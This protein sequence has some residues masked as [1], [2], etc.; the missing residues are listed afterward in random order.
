MKFKFWVLTILFLFGFVQPNL[1]AQNV[2]FPSIEPSFDIKSEKSGVD[3]IYITISEDP[4][5]DV[6]DAYQIWYHEFDESGNY[7]S[8]KKS[9][10]SNQ[11]A[12]N[13]QINDSHGYELCM[14][15]LD[16]QSNPVGCSFVD[17]INPGQFIETVSVQ[18]VSGTDIAQTSGTS[19]LAATL[20]I[21]AQSFPDVSLLSKITL[22]GSTYDIAELDDSNIKVYEDGRLQSIVRIIPPEG[23][24][25]KSVDIVFV[26]DDSGSLGN[27]AAQVKANIATFLSQLDSQNFDYRVALVP[28]GGAGSSSSYSSPGGTIL[29]SGQM[30]SDGNSLISDINGM[31]FNGGTERAF[32]AMQLATN[33]INWRS[34]SQKVIILVTDENND[35]GCLGESALISLLTD[36]NVTVYALTAGHSEFTRIAEATGGKR[37]SVTASFTSILTEIGEAIAS[38][39]I[40]EY[41][42]DN[43]TLDGGGREVELVINAENGE[44]ETVETSV[45]GE[46][47]PSLPISIVPTAATTALHD[48][49]QRQYQSLT[50]IVKATGGSTGI[51]SCKLY[52]KNQ[53]SSYSSVTMSDSGNDLYSATIPASSV[54]EPYV[55][56]YITATDGQITATLPSSDASSSPFVISVF[57]NVNPVINHSPVLTASEN[58]AIEI[59]ANVQDATNYI[60]E[61]TL[62]YREA[63]TSV[64]SSI[65]ANPN[66]E[67]HLF[68]TNIPAGTVTSTGVEYYLIA[69]DD[70]GGESTYGTA[71]DPVVVEVTG[72]LPDNGY[73]DIGNIRVWADSFLENTSDSNI[74]TAS[75]HVMV[76]TTQG[77][78]KLLRFSTSLVLDFSINSVEGVSSSTI[79]ALNIKRNP[80]KTPENF[81]LYDGD[82][83]ID[84]TVNPPKMTIENGTSELRLIGSLA[85][86]YNEVQDEVTIGDN[87]LTINDVTA[88]IT[89]GI[90]IIFTVGD[91][92][93]SQDGN[94]QGEFTIS[95]AD[96]NTAAKIY[97]SEWELPD[98]SLTLDTV[99]PAITGSAKI[100][101]PGKIKS[102]DA[103]VSFDLGFILSPF[104]LETF[105]GGISL[106]SNVQ[107]LLT[108]PTTPPSALGVSLKDGSIL[109]D[110]ISQAPSGLQLTGSCTVALRDAA[111][112]M[113]S[114]AEL[115]LDPV[116]GKLALTIDFNGKVR[117]VGD[118]DFIEHF[119]LADGE[120]CFG[121][122]SYVKGGINIVDVLL[123]DV[124]FAVGVASGYVDMTGQ[125]NLTFQI[126]SKAPWIGGY[127]LYNQSTYGQFRFNSSSISRAEFRTSYQLFFLDLTVRLDVSDPSDPDLFI[128]GLDKT[129]Q[130]FG[131]QPMLLTALSENTEYTVQISNQYSQAVVR[132]TADS[133]TPLFN[134]TTP[135]GVTHTPS[136][137][138]PS[139]SPD[140][141][142]ASSVS[143][144]FFMK[145][146][147]ANESF[148]GIENPE[149]GTYT[150]TLTNASE[151]SN[152][153]VGVYYPNTA[154][155]I[156]IQEPATDQVFVSDP[157][158]ISWTGQ[159]P[160]DNAVVSLYYDT[161]NSGADGQLI[162]ADINLNSETSYDWAIDDT[163]P[164]GKYYIYAVADDGCNAFKIAYSTG[165]VE[166]NN[167][168]APAAPENLQ[169]V[170]GDG[171]LTVSWDAVEDATLVGYRIY[172]STS[173]GDGE[174]ED[175]IAVGTAT[176]YD[177]EG[178]VNGQD[179]EVA[180]TAENEQFESPKTDSVTAAP[181]GSSQGGT[182]DLIVDV[183]NCSVSSSSGVHTGTVTVNISVL[184]QGEYASYSGKVTCYRGQ[185]SK[186]NVVGTKLLAGLDPEENIEFSFT[187]DGSEYSKSEADTFFVVIDDVSLTELKTDNNIGVFANGLDMLGDINGDDV[188]DSSDYA[189]FQAA[190]N[191]CFGDSRFVDL[192]DIDRDGCITINDYRLL[193]ALVS[194]Q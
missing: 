138:T 141:F 182:P 30:H 79:T 77:D 45:T 124:S 55:Y 17:E 162:A 175:D 107:N 140:D 87:S 126:P 92:V 26:H 36:N 149:G 21:D 165:T 27:E 130:V 62:Y 171:K 193:R 189:A 72:E 71:D 33:S 32:C 22:D 43:P 57:P 78:S 48:S 19:S 160:D 80:S 121:N 76:G 129:I 13:F 61:V 153:N 188:I 20:E 10:I 2:D 133:G 125:S 46:Y 174:Y 28:Y 132:V 122:P 145:N 5:S 120:I 155:T 50:I 115:G 110:K 179:Y 111:M 38:N 96:F 40:I 117:L 113:S 159:D 69:K 123:G 136:S 98:M 75:G 114:L 66:T 39:Y 85:L 6:G 169:V 191:S 146:D 14:V 35:S 41:E 183:E 95:S 156:A 15:V 177:I 186:D 102:D 147:G 93:L 81:I 84:C 52:Y 128:T 106:S 172:L 185:I 83:K 187:F 29:H 23:G 91:I 148:Y 82:F 170:S 74:Y 94:S 64:Y 100:K 67:E 7:V 184:N 143:G 68:N 150:I 11:P 144:I 135:S 116:T 51:Q 104:A 44:G 190:F 88:H 142:G 54:A 178:L 59:K 89:Q 1:M 73:M 137:A 139:V 101:I 161:D 60:T 53:S 49:G 157:V 42:T 99:T 158:R 105:G 58:N 176:S 90:N 152:V 181:S 25:T 31:K 37:F 180:L 4:S 3:A 47:T 12:F 108:I 166:V 86:Q 63:G 103:G 70:L 131:T 119:P 151:V 127:Q 18:L 194:N 168:T 192:A 109:I 97:G 9:E 34:S 112:N 167:A 118:I 154:P 164:S 65:T 134:L 24:D 16:S 173:I 8:F 163:V 56:Y